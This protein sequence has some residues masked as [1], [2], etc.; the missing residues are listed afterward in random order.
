MYAEYNAG[1]EVFEELLEEL[2][3]KLME[4]QGIDRTEVDRKTYELHKIGEDIQ[5]LR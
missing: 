4:N 2:K 5:A 3:A 1:G